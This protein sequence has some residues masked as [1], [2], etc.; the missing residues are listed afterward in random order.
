MDRRVDANFVRVYEDTWKKAYRVAYA[1][2]RDKMDAE[3]VVQESFVKLWLRLR[4]P[5]LRDAEAWLLRVTYNAACRRSKARCRGMTDE[6]SRALESGEPTPEDDVI[7]RDVSS[8]VNKALEGL[9]LREEQLV[10][11]KYWGRLTD[12]QISRLLQMPEGTVKSR[13][14]A[15]RGKLGKMLKD[16]GP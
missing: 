8:E 12:N 6:T 13:L 16:L 14:H 1:I 2:C 15:I 5:G 7:S 3:D 4:L 11:L 10:R 9:P